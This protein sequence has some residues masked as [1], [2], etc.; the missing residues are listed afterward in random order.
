MTFFTVLYTCNR[1][2]PCFRTVEARDEA[3][4]REVCME[5]T[6]N[7]KRVDSIRPYVGTL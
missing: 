7:L 5:M 1:D 4:A 3:H 2:F 6:H